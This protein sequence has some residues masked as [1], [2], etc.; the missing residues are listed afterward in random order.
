[1]SKKAEDSL[2]YKGKSDVLR[3]FQKNTGAVLSAVASR[4]FSLMPG[5]AIETLTGIEFDSKFKL[6]EYN[7]KLMSDAIDRELKQLGL[8]NDIALK[9]AIVL[10]ETEK[11]QFFSDLQKE[12]ADKELIRSLTG[13]DIAAL[14]MD[15]EMRETAV[16]MAKVAI[17]VE[18][19]GIK[20]QKEEV[21]LLPLPAE[22]QLSAAKLA[23][24]QRKLAVIP[25]ILAALAA[26]SNALETESSVIMPAREAK[27]NYES[28]IASDMST[29]I[30]PLMQDKAAATL[31][32][33]E[34]QSELIPLMI[35]KAQASMALAEEMT[36]QLENHRLLAQ[37]K[38]AL[39]MA[40]VAR[41]SEEMVLMGKELTLDGKKLTIE[42]D[43]AELELQ[44]ADARLVV[45]DAMR[46]QLGALKTA[47][48][49]ESA[50]EI[51]LINIQ[52]A[53]E[54]AVK[55]SQIENVEKAKY[56]AQAQDIE[57]NISKAYS[58]GHADSQHSI[59][60]ANKMANAEITE[61]LIHLLE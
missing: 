36:A 46:V 22:E 24:A 13:E 14:M 38:V 18:I 58:M 48:T 7:Q 10:W 23:A 54:I 33:T 53:N 12:F 35:E 5:F 37:E 21:D 47:M 6:M 28:T 30:L 52:G 39:A 32:L 61:R 2:W 20:R 42:R 44:R 4:D 49:T 56:A 15:Q 60:N 27:A 41:I 17:E 29:K 19:E 51:A 8:E 45:I 40:K 57:S 43:R 11:I 34:K 3:E 9:Q 31:T 55:K 16:L 25:H 26:Q 1:M 50:A 59:D